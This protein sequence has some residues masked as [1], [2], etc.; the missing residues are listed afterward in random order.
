M[1]NILSFCDVEITRQENLDNFACHVNLCFIKDKSILSFYQFLPSLNFV[2][3]NPIFL[4]STLT[5]F[6]TDVDVK[7]CQPKRQTNVR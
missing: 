6:Y 2:Y 3:L 1:Q 7:E 4:Y 5:H